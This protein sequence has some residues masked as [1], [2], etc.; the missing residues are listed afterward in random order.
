MR[1]GEGA[2]TRSARRVAV[3]IGLCCV[4]LGTGPTVARGA[5][6][7][8]PAWARHTVGPAN[9]VV[10]GAALGVS[11]DGSRIFVTT[12]SGAGLDDYDTVAYDAHGHRLWERRYD[13]PDHLAA[14]PTALAV[15]PGG[16]RVFVTGHIEGATTGDDYATIAYQARTGAT[17]WTARYDG[18]EGGADDA[19][20]SIGVSPD[21]SRVFVTG[22]SGAGDDLAT[23]AYDAVTGSQQ[24]VTRY[25]PPDGGGYFDGAG[26]LGVSPDGSRVFVTGSNA[27]FEDSWIDYTTIAYDALTGVELWARIYNG[28]GNGIDQ[29]HELVVTPD[30][31]GVIVTGSSEGALGDPNFATVRYDA[32]TGDQVWVRRY[33]GPHNAYD[34]PTDIGVSPDGSRV[35]VTGT[36][37]RYGGD[38][39]NFTTVAYTGAGN[40]LW[41]RRYD[42]PASGDDVASALAVSPDG[43][44]VFVTGQTKT[45]TGD[46]LGTMAYDATTGVQLWSARYE[47]PGWRGLDRVGAL[48]VSP[49]GGRVYVTGLT[50]EG[51]S[52]VYTTVAYRV[53]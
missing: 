31:S 29:A 52:S 38:D 33:D 43:S 8:S 28:P 22:T 7:V 32:V 5:G 37:Y 24:W 25:A 12:R 6:L 13:G 3:L 45:P 17:L 39:G 26:E 21:G 50:H 35:F 36:S 1:P 15:S 49:G 10:A 41:S 2:R 53:P 46:G 30:G 14:G 47:Q 48:R 4:G 40:E 51:D 9:A 34:Y 20:S 27:P 23:V 18:E 19:A 44:A 42:G 11:P 16:A